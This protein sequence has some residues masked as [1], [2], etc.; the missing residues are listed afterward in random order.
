MKTIADSDIKLVENEYFLLVYAK[1][2]TWQS[3]LYL[4]KRNNRL[5]NI[6]NNDHAAFKIDGNKLYIDWDDWDA[7]TY[8]KQTLDNVYYYEK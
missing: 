3:Y 2:K 8:T 6:N 5:Y 7:E 1:H 4:N